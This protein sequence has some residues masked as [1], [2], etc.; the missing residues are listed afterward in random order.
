VLHIE[1]P[2][3]VSTHAA[4]APHGAPLDREDWCREFSNQL[5]GRLKNKLLPMGVALK[6]G[7]ATL[8]P[9]ATATVQGVP[10]TEV[11]RCS[12]ISGKGWLRAELSMHVSPDFTPT[13]QGEALLEGTYLMF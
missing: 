13:T 6:V 4:M 2:L 9:S 5:G 1:A 12:F 7:L 11:Q 3:L 8:D 10:A